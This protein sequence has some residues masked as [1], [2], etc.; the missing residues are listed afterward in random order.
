MDV[1]L[2]REYL[3]TALV[4]LDER[5]DVL[6]LLT[7]VGRHVVIDS[8]QGAVRPRDRPASLL[9]AFKGLRRRDLV[10]QVAINV[11]KGGT[12]RSAIDDVIVPY[13]VIHVRGP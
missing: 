5:A 7:R 6:E 10:N 4:V 1:L 8:D 13:F 12:V 9:Q 3:L 2:D 11:Q